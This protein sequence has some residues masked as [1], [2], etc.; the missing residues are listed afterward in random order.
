[1][2]VSPRPKIERSTR[3]AGGLGED[4]QPGLQ[5]GGRAHDRPRCRAVSQVL[6]GV[7]LGPEQ[8]GRTVRCCTEH[9]HEHDVRAGCGRRVDE[10]GVSVLIDLDRSGTATAQEAVDRRDDDAG[11]CDQFVEPV[12]TSHVAGDHLDI[13]TQHAAGAP[14]VADD[15]RTRSPRASNSLTTC[16]PSSPLPPATTIM[17]SRL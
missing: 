2:G 17:S 3:G 4:R 16:R 15:T 10:V 12:A 6:F 11:A 7:V 8:F 5:V 13:V 1:M 14:R 9:G